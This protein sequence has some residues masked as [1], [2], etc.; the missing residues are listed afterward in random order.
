MVLLL[1][2]PFAGGTSMKALGARGLIVFTSWT[3]VGCSRFRHFET[4]PAPLLRPESVP[5]GVI[6]AETGPPFA[7]RTT[8][9]LN[10][11]L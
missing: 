2:S 9:W 4:Q 1:A 3:A 5:V 6:K 11:Y 10:C 7:K 8:A